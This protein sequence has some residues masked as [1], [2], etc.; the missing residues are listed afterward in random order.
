MELYGNRFWNDATDNRNKA[1]FTMQEET[2]RAVAAKLDAEGMN[3]CAFSHNDSYKMAVNA[4]DVQYFCEM[5]GE[6]LSAQMEAAEA[7]RDNTPQTVIGTTEYRS[8]PE[9]RYFTSDTDMVLKVAEQLQAQGI[10]FSGR[11]YEDH[12]TLTVSAANEQTV[13]R[14]NDAILNARQQHRHPVTQHMVVGNIPYR[15]IQQPSCFMSRLKPQEFM[16]IKPVIDAAE[17]PYSG[18]VKPNGIILTVNQSDA[19]RFAVVLNAAQTKQQSIDELNEAGFSEHQIAVLD[20]AL[21]QFAAAN[22][23]SSIL[24]FVDPRFNDEQL[25]HIAELAAKYITQSEADRIFDRSGILLDLIQYRDAARRQIAFDETFRDTNYSAEQRTAL[26]ALYESGMTAETLNSFFDE[27]YTVEEMERVGACF[28]ESDCE[29][30]QKIQQAHGRAETPKLTGF[31]PEPSDIAAAAQMRQAEEDLRRDIP[32]GD[33]QP[34]MDEDDSPVITGADGT[35]EIY[36]LQEAADTERIRFEDYETLQ[37]LGIGISAAQ[38]SCIYT[39]ELSGDTA[40]LDGIFYTL[41]ENHPADFN[42]YSLSVGDIIVR[43]QNGERTAHFVDRFGFRELP[44]FFRERET[45]LF[46]LPFSDRDRQIIGNTPFKYIKGKT[47]HTHDTETAMQIAQELASREIRF[48]G[49]INGDS[50]TLTI[51]ADAEEQYQEIAAEFAEP[52][53]PQVDEPAE[54]EPAQPLV[55]HVGDHI[56]LADDPQT[57][58]IVT[59]VSDF[60]LKL[61]NADRSALASAQMMTGWQHHLNSENVTILPEKGLP[62]PAP[63]K[64]SAHAQQ[65]EGQL[66][67][68]AAEPDKSD[69]RRE[70]LVQEIMRGTGFENGKLRVSEYI[71]EHHPTAQELA[72]FLK[73]E[74]GIG[75]HSGSGDVQFADHDSKGIVIRTTDN[76]SFTY[77]WNEAAKVT[78]ELAEQGAYLTQ[79]D[80][81]EA[82]RNAHFYLTEFHDDE[83]NQ[84]Y[85]AIIEK[86]TKHPLITEALAEAAEPVGQEQ[87]EPTGPVEVAASEDGLLRFVLI[88]QEDDVHPWNVQRWS[89]SSVDEEFQYSG[90]GRHMNSEEDARGYAVAAVDRFDNEQCAQAIHNTVYENYQDNIFHS[91]IALARVQETYSTE[92]IALLLAVT[93]LRAD[94]DQ[95]YSGEVRD[96]ARKVILLHS[97]DEIRRAE[98][99]HFTVHPGLLNMLAETVMQQQAERIIAEPEITEAQPP[100]PEKPRN[101]MEHR[102]FKRMQELYPEIMQDNPNAHLYEHY[103]STNPRSGYEPF[104]IERISDIENGQCLISM[105][106]TYEQNGDLMRDPDIVLRVDFEKQTATAI[107]YRQDSLGIY[108][109]YPDGSTGQRDTNRFMLTWLKNLRV[110]E[111]EITRAAAQFVHEGIEYNIGLEY[112]NGKVKTIECDGHPEIEAAYAEAHGITLPEPIAADN[113]HEIQVGDRYQ[114]EGREFEVTQLSGLYPNDVTIAVRDQSGYALVQNIDRDTLSREGTYLGKQQQEAAQPADFTIP[115]DFSVAA[116]K[117]GKYQANIAAIQMLKTIE[118]EGRSATPD[119]QKILAGYVGWGGI[120]EAFDSDNDAWTQEYTQLRDLLKPEEYAAARASTENAH[121]TQPM[122]ISAMYRALEQFGFTG[123]RVLEPSMGIG[124]FFGAMPENMRAAS[125]LYGVELDSISGRIAKQLYPSAD[126]AVTGFEHT[127]FNNG[128]FDVVVGNVPFGNYRVIDAAYDEEKFKIHDYFLAKSVDKLK[129]RG[130]MAVVTSSGTMDKLDASARQYLAAR[131]DLVG[132]VR[133]PNTAFKANAGAEVTTDIL[134]FRKREEPLAQDAPFPEWTELGETADGLRVN[135]YFA[136]HPEMVLGTLQVSSNPFS[137]GVECVPLPETDLRIQL[138]EALGRLSAEISQERSTVPVRAEQ[139]ADDAPLKTY[140]LRD[141]NLYFRDS[142]QKPAEL[143]ELT[144]KKRER[145]VGM[146]GIRD[147]ARAVIQAQTENCSDEELRKLQALLTEQYDAFYKKFGLIHAKANAQVFREDD[148][149]ALICSLEKTYDIKKGILAE[150]ADIFTKRTINAVIAVDHTESAEDALIISMQYRGRI[151]FP[152]MS[153]LCGKTKEELIA[154]LKR[155]IYPVPDLAHPEHITYQ[156]ADEY[157]SGNIRVKLDEARAAAAQNPLFAA[158]I[159]ALEAVMPEKIRAGDIT[160]RLGATWIPEKYVRQFMYEMLQ[161]PYYLQSQE[162]VRSSRARWQRDRIN[163]EFLPEV[164]LWHVTNPRQDRSIRSTRDFGTD[165][166]TAYEILDDVLN[167]RSPK[168]YKTVADPNAERGEKRVIDG[169]ATSLVQK[170]AAALQQ[171]FTEWIFRD[172]ERAADLVERYNA[173]FNSTR[174]R[175]YD[176][177]HMVFPGMAS[178]ITLLPHQKN[179][180]AHA[181]YGGNTLFAHCVGAGKTFEMIATAMEGKR[182]GLHKKS[183]F[184]VPKHLTEQIGEDFLRLY[185]SANILVATTHDFSASRRRELMA[186]IATG[187]YDAVII[188]HEQFRMLPLSAERATRQMQA[189]VDALTESID[190]ERAASGGR[191]FTVKAMERQRRSLQQQIEKL[192]AAAKR[193]E[194]NVTFEQL[195]IDHIFVD[196]AHEFKNLFCP[197]KLQNLSGVSTSASQKAMDLFLK[198]RYLDEETGGRGIT[199]ATGTPLSNSITEL[200]TMMRYLEYDFLKDHGLQHFDNW[201]AVVTHPKGQPNYD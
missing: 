74:Y 56:R 130:I 13:L 49:K 30:I 141:G 45:D 75:G 47:Y 37:K 127:Y 79:Q 68:F 32:A 164:G 170:K 16:Q 168:V 119:E 98:S 26:F 182:L 24:T 151:D 175:E 133:L 163:V 20:S 131:A 18:I 80:I 59:E 57:T 46:A 7:S 58:W 1:F 66:A 78:A 198:C 105:M 139:Y 201:V 121:Y 103:E 54:S 114:Y 160:V 71:E 42:A 41:N 23:W 154:D 143:S 9:K 12:A 44:D 21:D 183:L 2:F 142:A 91:D 31:D 169:E 200:H 153:E 100:A 181:L 193:D 148:G 88:H 52:E 22:D 176:G 125:E 10:P 92:R 155:K 144:G 112:E 157:L 187:N 152:Y 190:R 118:S 101:T 69:R 83:R 35:F 179:A 64:R 72:D 137:S 174:P 159:P 3:Y 76:Q 87:P 146:I 65:T 132:A 172:P 194:Q 90:Y 55:L 196:E 116:G 150:K 123:G 156:T 199:L 85:A 4:A 191:N 96:W 136:E 189:E 147:A 63:K 138:A 149:F 8:I 39:G 135:S 166:M 43:N 19:E 34:L 165:A 126:I 62:A 161:T 86:Y 94:W 60:I 89:R 99:V 33:W 67:L 29:G 188:S 111:R 134:I 184:V 81:V 173:L 36:R 115:D 6:E 82:I 38:Y 50:T 128:A 27:S 97:D 180:V 93:A 109:E 17:I 5:L 104:A 77:S 95:R 197:T 129:A 106:H 140:F 84:Y 195:G 110:Q 124:H 51:P 186:R 117:K 108:R 178:D 61:E 162:S 70:L 28:R 192:V 25:T 171:A 40:T 158:N 102:I 15:D 145:V 48:S 11:V 14:I 122:I 113:T 120:P 185:P 167:L 53:A 177:S 73:K 107:S